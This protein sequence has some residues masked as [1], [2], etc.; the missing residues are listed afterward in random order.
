[1][2]TFFV[3]AKLQQEE[4]HDGHEDELASAAASSAALVCVTLHH[5]GMPTDG[6]PDEADSPLDGYEYLITAY[7]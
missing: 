3:L 5:L 7:T 6:S 1:M 2:L 4:L